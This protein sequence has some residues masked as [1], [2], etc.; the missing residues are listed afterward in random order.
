MVEFKDRAQSA[1]EHHHRVFEF[2]QRLYGKLISRIQIFYDLL[3]RN[4]PDLMIGFMSYDPEYV[5]DIRRLHR[6]LSWT[7]QRLTEVP[8]D[9]GEFSGE[10]NVLGSINIIKYEP[11][12]GPIFLSPH[13][14]LE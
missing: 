5:E 13:G 3:L 12:I 11:P 1:S 8:D 6:D 9:R 7:L 14:W 10:G 4:S 2:L